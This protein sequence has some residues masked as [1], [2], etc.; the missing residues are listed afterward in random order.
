[1]DNLINDVICS[2]C[3]ACV[4]IC[5]QNCIE[6]SFDD[7]GFLYPIKDNGKCNNCGLCIDVCYLNKELKCEEDY[8]IIGAKNKNK[9]IRFESSSGG[10]FTVFAEHIIKIGGVVFGA[11]YDESHYVCHSYSETLDGLGKFRKSKYV[12]SDTKNTFIEAERFLKDGKTVLYSGCPCQ[13]AGLKSYLRK[14]YENLYCVD[15]IC[16][17]VNSPGVFDSY[18]RSVEKE[19]NSKIRSI[20]MR[21]KS[22]PENIQSSDSLYINII[23]DNGTSISQL[24]GTGKNQN[25]FFTGFAENLYLRP[26]CHNCKAKGFSSGSDIQLGDFWGIEK[27]NAN[28]CDKINNGNTIVPFG[29][30]EVILVS[31]K[32]KKLFSDVSAALDYFTL[33]KEWFLSS[34]LIANYLSLNF[35]SKPHLHRNEFFS[36]YKI[37]TDTQQNIKK[38]ISLGPKPEKDHPLNYKVVRD[39]AY[40]LLTGHKI[41]NYL[42]QKGIKKIAVYGY[43]DIGKLIELALRESSVSIEFFIDANPE[44]NNDNVINAKDDIPN[45]V[46]TIIIS[47]PNFN[48]EIEA[49]LKKKTDIPLISVADLISLS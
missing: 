15:L 36:E 17:G 22:F 10:L 7:E 46:D 33:D 11:L 14:D 44:P 16:H 25:Y 32:G 1:M 2:G 28:F 45:T 40:K 23:F 21:E 26:S 30:S 24:P 20:S 38:H 6:M 35:S 34:K 31:E 4:Q 27:V 42:C 13:I 41:D 29:I 19:Y 12:Q 18:L 47:V 37:G 8:V 48:D 5:P 3:G 49:F 43:G 39:F 9:Q